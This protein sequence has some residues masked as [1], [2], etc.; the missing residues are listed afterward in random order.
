MSESSYC[1]PFV[2][3]IDGGTREEVVLQC[4]WQCNEIER[5]A[6]LD[7]GT[8]VGKA[9]RMDCMLSSTRRLPQL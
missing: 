3:S 8:D 6:N 2:F 4:T 1:L 7:L 9:V 5:S